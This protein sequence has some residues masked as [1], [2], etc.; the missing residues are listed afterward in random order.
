M[1]RGALSTARSWRQPSRCTGDGRTGGVVVS[2]ER[3]R[4][5]G[6][7]ER[8]HAVL[9]SIAEGA[10]ALGEAPLR[11]ADLAIVPQDHGDRDGVHDGIVGRCGSGAGGPIVFFKG[12]VPD[13]VIAFDQLVTAGPGE[14]VLR[15]CAASV[16]GNGLCDV[17]TW[18]PMA[19]KHRLPLLRVEGL[20][21]P[22]QGRSGDRLMA[23]GDRV[24]PAA[25][26]RKILLI[27]AGRERGRGHRARMT[28]RRDSRLTDSTEAMQG[29]RPWLRR[30]SSICAMVASID[31]NG[32]MFRFEISV[33][34][35]H[36]ARSA[37]GARNRRQALRR[38]GRP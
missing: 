16:D 21:N 28:I 19:L 22:M 3:S 32:P 10:Q 7:E 12:D 8:L 13:M 4:S 11:F 33:S 30:T 25:D 26:G 15:C 31:G 2:G 20:H 1:W 38:N 5:E 17:Q 27:K 23:T 24:L 35:S 9:A 34:H 36:A 6:R 14:P 18:L 29:L 37:S